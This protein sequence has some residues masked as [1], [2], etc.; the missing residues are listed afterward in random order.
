MPKNIIVPGNEPNNAG[1]QPPYSPFRIPSCRR[2]VEYDE[3]IVVYFGGMCGSPCCL[4]L[5]VS[6]ECINRSPVVPPIPPAIM[7]YYMSE[8]LLLCCPAQAYMK[9]GPPCLL[10]IRFLCHNIRRSQTR[11]ANLGACEVFLCAWQSIIEDPKTTTLSLR[12]CWSGEQVCDRWGQG[13]GP[14]SDLFWLLC[15]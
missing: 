8:S 12:L 14:S 5:T 4:V 10:L 6:K 7:H 11:C 15:L 13:H 3:A 9:V 1:T 2:I